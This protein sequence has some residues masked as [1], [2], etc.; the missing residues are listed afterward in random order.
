VP[1]DDIRR[2]F[3]RGLQRFEQHY[4]PIADKWAVYDNTGAKPVLIESGP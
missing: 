1:A 3:D 2:R 4:R